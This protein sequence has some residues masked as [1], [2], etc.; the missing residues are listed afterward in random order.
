MTTA[1]TEFSLTLS[2]TLSDNTWK[3]IPA[4]TQT[5]TQTDTVEVRSLLYSLFLPG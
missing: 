4:F 3:L 1:A 2:Q 5:H